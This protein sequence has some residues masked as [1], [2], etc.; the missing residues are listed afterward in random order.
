MMFRVCEY[1][2]AHLDPGEPCDCQNEKATV[3]EY[4]CNISTA[5]NINNPQTIKKEETTDVIRKKH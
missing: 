4:R 1:C 5:Q 2:S 3:E